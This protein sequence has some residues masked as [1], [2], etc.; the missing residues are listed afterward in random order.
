VA[1]NLN[2][3]TL[4]SGAGIDVGSIVD[5]LVEAARAPERLWQAQQLKLKA[6]QAALNELNTDLGDLETRLMD[7]KDP[8]GPLG[9]F[10]T[11]SSNESVLSAT[12]EPGATT[13]QHTIVVSQLAD[14]ASFY[15]NAVA[16][17]SDPINGSISIKVGTADIV[18][19]AIDSSNNT[20]DALASAIN[21]KQLGVTASVI[22]DATGSR[23]V[24]VGNNSGMANDVVVTGSGSLSFTQSTFAQN[25]KLTIDGVPIESATNTVTGAI[26]GLTIKLQGAKPDQA[27]ALTVEQDTGRVAS[28][29]SSFVGSFNAL[30]VAIN[31]QFTYNATTNAAGALSG[32]PSV[33]ALQQT[34]LEQISYT[35][36]GTDAIHTLA[37]LGITMN[38]D[39]T[40]KV[41]AAALNTVLKDNF[42]AVKSFL[43]G[44]GIHGFAV[45]FGK[46]MG[47]LTD[48]TRGPIVIDLKG[49]AENQ[50]ILKDQIDSF[51]LQLAVRQQQWLDQFSRIDAILRQF[52][53][54]Q[55]Q[56]AASLGS[57]NNAK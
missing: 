6:Q 28:A 29:I 39:G 50:Q 27:V 55:Q 11:S 32:D 40:L 24:V 54:Q 9:G 13:G 52:P 23:L 47:N 26:P 44:D 14:K 56:L 34:L 53:L 17:V 35:S 37:S 49:N 8:L 30:I 42:E 10:T 46:I 7:L 12:A 19:I 16:N 31:K 41:D 36:S 48:P 43:Q 20:L 21:Q 45:E 51:E 1:T 38:D 18:S 4:S 57:L 3:T 15:S 33:R 5:N 2:S 22:T 25:A